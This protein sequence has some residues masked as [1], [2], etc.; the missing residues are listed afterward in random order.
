ME[1]MFLQEH[2]AFAVREAC[3]ELLR[4]F[5]D[6]L[7]LGLVKAV[8]LQVLVSVEGPP[9]LGL[10]CIGLGRLLQLLAVHVDKGLRSL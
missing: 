9:L 8:H 6:S 7:L 2:A 1:G 3:V 5:Q 4:L 10:L